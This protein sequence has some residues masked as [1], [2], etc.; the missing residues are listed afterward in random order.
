MG[1]DAREG[2]VPRPE[3]GL[4]HVHLD[5]AAILGQEPDL[6]SAS[7]S[8]N[9]ATRVLGVPGAQEVA[10]EDAQPV[11]A[12]LRLTAVGIEDPHAE[13]PW[14]I[15]DGQGTQQDPVGTDPEAPVTEGL[16][17][18]WRHLEGGQGRIQHEVV[19]TERL[20]F[21]EGYFNGHGLV[22]GPDQRVMRVPSTCRNWAIQAGWAGQ[23]G[24]VT[25]FPSVTAP[26]MAISAYLPLASFT[27]GPQAG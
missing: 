6:R 2:D 10:G 18:P 14:I 23:A 12:L 17:E 20:E 3:A 9:A 13:R 11:P 1:G 24:A 7:D 19:A 5:Q 16:G 15:G 22:L 26:S 21:E 27:S 4:A 8:V 25:R